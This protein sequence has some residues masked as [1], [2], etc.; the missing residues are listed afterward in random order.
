MLYWTPLAVAAHGKPL[1]S[2]LIELCV[3]VSALLVVGGWLLSSIGQLNAT[4]YA[5]WLIATSLI[6]WAWLQ[7]QQ[8]TT[9]QSAGCHWLRLIRRIRRPLPMM[10]LGLTLLAALGAV[11][12]PPANLDG[13]NQ[14][15]PRVLNW[16]LANRW[17]WIDPAPASFNT[18]P[19]N[20]EWLSAPLILFTNTDRWM[21]ILNI[22]AYLLLPGLIFSVWTQLGVSRRVAWHWMWLLPTGYC[23]LLQA[24]SVYN[25]AFGAVYALAAIHFALRARRSPRGWDLE[26]S[27]VAAA[28]MTAVKPV[29]FALLIPWLIAA[30]P[31]LPRLLRRPIIAAVSLAIGALVSFAP[32]AYLNQRHCGDWTG[33]TIALPTDRFEK[34]NAPE[35]LLGNVIF[36]L[37]DNLTPPIFPFAGWWNAHIPQLVPEGL[38]RALHKDVGRGRDELRLPELQVEESAGLGL[39]LVVLLIVSFVTARPAWPRI[40]RWRSASLWLSPYLAFLAYAAAMMIPTA[41]RYL[42]SYY[43]L[44]LPVWLMGTG[45]RWVVRRNWWKWL[46][47]AAMVVAAG[48]LVLNPARPLWPAVSTSSWLYRN[49]P[50]NA[51][52]ERVHRVYAAYADRWDGMA[53]VRRAL[54]A[55]A[56]E[57][58]L[59]VCRPASQSEASLWRPFGFRRV[60]DLSVNQATAIIKQHRLRYVVVGAELGASLVQNRPF[61]EWFADWTADVHGQ[62]IATTH[63]QL[64]AARGEATWYI[65]RIQK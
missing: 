53:G 31:A 1:M 48:V 39:G 47:F 16:L 3:V 35:A 32:T 18:W 9:N 58:G 22:A 59:L 4:G 34:S 42:A 19:C 63:S 61:S 15:V 2:M 36:T 26:L 8:R 50:N 49:H 14:R 25:D 55:D 44:L 24:G 37:R 33:I 41:A 20:F 13:L 27:L 28:F 65:L 62:V 43:P 40:W 17:Y 57:I 29:N 64:L 52:F 6:T 46:E 21:F 7:R 60:L 45:H 51:L 12:H 54:P 23:F 10:F 56:R 38:H 11:L 5:V 30:A